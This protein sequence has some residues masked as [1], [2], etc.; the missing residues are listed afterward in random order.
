[1]FLLALESVSWIF[2][3]FFLFVRKLLEYWGIGCF[4]LWIYLVVFL[5]L[6]FVCVC[7]CLCVCLVVFEPWVFM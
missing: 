2:C 5:F 7:V 3:V 4:H 6:L 1:M